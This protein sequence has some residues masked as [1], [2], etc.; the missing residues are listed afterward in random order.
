M[1][2]EDLTRAFLNAA[3]RLSEEK[4]DGTALTLGADETLPL[5][6]LSRSRVV[7]RTREE[8]P[9]L[10]PTEAKFRDRWIGQQDFLG[11]FLAFS[12]AIRRRRLEESLAALSD[13]LESSGADFAQAVH[14]VAA[15]CLRLMSEPPEY[16]LQLMA[17]ASTDDPAT[18]KL[19]SDSLL[20]ITHVVLE[21]Y[22][23]V[24]HRFGFQ[25][26]PGIDAEQLCTLLHALADG[27]AMRVIS[28]SK[29]RLVDASKGTS[30]L[31]TGV[32]ALLTSL[33]DPGDGASLEEAA[34]TR[35]RFRS[36]RTAYSA[37]GPRHAAVLASPG[38]PA[39]AA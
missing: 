4:F 33:I 21:A 19:L 27:L 31:G 29:G 1:A 10:V 26:R 12:L 39:G 17:G 13:E 35:M 25:L 20:S 15:Y 11:D 28:G 9:E 37:A 18:R 24:A 5:A 23:R 22:E 2:N 8:R 6:F 30:L 7:G 34:A 36:S 16:R 3:L 14:G 38:I 32:L